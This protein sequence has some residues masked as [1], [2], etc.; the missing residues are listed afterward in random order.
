MADIPE[1]A[2]F[3]LLSLLFLGMW[4]FFP[5]MAVKY[6][7]PKSAL[8]FQAGGALLCGIFILFYLGFD[9][10]FNTNG[11][12]YAVLTGIAGVLG[13][14][15]LYFAL[16]KGGKLSVVV[17]VSALYPLISIAMGYLVLKEMISLKQSLGIVMALLSIVLLTAT[18]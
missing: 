10:S 5:K 7:D 9:I 1:W 11:I 4:G 17:T 14:I 12:I 16:S 6:L 18:D 15:F 13:T 2:L 8:V 3:T